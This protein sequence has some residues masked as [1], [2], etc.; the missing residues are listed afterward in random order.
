MV[1]VKVA[2]TWGRTQ[3]FPS[4][5]CPKHH[6]APAGLPSSGNCCKQTRPSKWRPGHLLPLLH[7]PVLMLSCSL[8]VLSAVD[9]VSMG[10]LTGLQLCSPVL[11][12]AMRILT[13]FYQ[14]QDQVFGNL[15]YSNSSVALDHMGQP[16]HDPVAGSPSFLVWPSFGRYWP[17]QTVNPPIF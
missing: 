8:L 12:D 7:G 17:L 13:P 15:S 11:Y 6:T 5:H 9:G 1:R 3:S 4:E 10:T 2:S 14:N 16:L